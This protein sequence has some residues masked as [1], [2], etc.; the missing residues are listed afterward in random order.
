MSKDNNLSELQISILDTLWENGELSVHEVQELLKN[1]RDLAATTIATILKRLE[2]RGVVSYRKI[3]RK[4]IY[5]ADIA[6]QEV[7]K[8][9][10]SSVVRNLFKGNK[11]AL[12]SH[13]LEDEGL[14]KDELE[15][16][17]D[18]IQEKTKSNA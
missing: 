16:I 1:K 8:N 14:S 18:L 12:V 17:Q 13:L 11:A 9:S 2:K 3:G 15:Q 10:I 6:K 5:K 4:F 7:T